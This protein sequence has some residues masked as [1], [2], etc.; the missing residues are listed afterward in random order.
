MVS[1][2]V[3]TLE[4]NGSYFV[5]MEA[6]R[7]VAEGYL[8]LNQTG[9]LS[10]YQQRGIQYPRVEV[11]SPTSPRPAITHQLRPSFPLLFVPLTRLLL[12]LILYLT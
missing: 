8:N 3:L 10:E 4:A 12:H 7:A 2:N 11:M 1:D 9:P 6:R 5:T